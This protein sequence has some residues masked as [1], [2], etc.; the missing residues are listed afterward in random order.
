MGKSF[1]RTKYEDKDNHV[2][3]SHKER[4]GARN[5]TQQWETEALDEEEFLNTDARSNEEA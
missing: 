3:E 2:R 5:Q 1:K 4:K